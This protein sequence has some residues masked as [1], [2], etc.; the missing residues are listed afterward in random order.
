MPSK[1]NS[2]TLFFKKSQTVN[3]KKSIKNPNNLRNLK[4]QL[5]SYQFWFSYLLAK[6]SIT[7]IAKLQGTVCSKLQ[8]RAHLT[9]GSSCASAPAEPCLSIVL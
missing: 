7:G 1:K 3:L 8:K 9:Y 2:A 6:I 5:S 4:I